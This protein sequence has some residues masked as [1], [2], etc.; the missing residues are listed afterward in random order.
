MSLS[1]IRDI[2]VL[3]EAPNNRFPVTTYVAEYDLGLISDAIK[4][5][6]AR[7]GQCFYLHNRIDTIYK[8]AQIIA[9]KKDVNSGI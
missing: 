4:R 6:I 9:D 5:E 3:N 1:G 8:T 7:G 2:S